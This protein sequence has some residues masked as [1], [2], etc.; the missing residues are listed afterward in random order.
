MSRHCVPRTRAEDTVP[1][2]LDLGERLLDL[3]QFSDVSGAVR[4]DHQEV[5]SPGV[6]HSLSTTR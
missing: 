4:V 1:V 3:L 5:A 6:Q 2:L